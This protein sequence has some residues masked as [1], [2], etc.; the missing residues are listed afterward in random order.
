M[1]TADNALAIAK[2]QLDQAEAQEVV[3]HNNL[4]YT[5]VKS[6]S[7]GV[8]GVLP[9]KTGALVSPAQPNP[10]TTVSD[11]SE[12]YVYFSMTENQLLSLIREY[13]SVENAIKSM[14]AIQLQ[15][16]D[17]STYS[18]N[19]RIETIS[20]I[21]DQVTGAVSL[22]AV[23]PNKGKLL[24]SGGAGNILIPNDKTDCIVI[25]KSATF[26]IQDKLYV[27]RNVDGTAKSSEIEVSFLSSDTE[28]IVETGLKA[29]DIIV[30]EG[31]GFIRENTPLQN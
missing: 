26:E 7:D 6:P 10:L 25:P 19:G 18:E 13:E 2:A 29:G 28:Y 31:A 22:R 1:Q 9:F 30:T 14:P 12:M 4:S 11:N 8:V 3:A 21:I 15:L 5:V 24:H 17:K 16:S 20:G 27:Y 23:F